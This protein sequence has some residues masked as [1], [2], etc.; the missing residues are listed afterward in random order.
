VILTGNYTPVSL[1]DIISNLFGH[2]ILF[3]IS[4]F[5]ATTGN[6]LSLV[7]SYCFSTNYYGKIWVFYKFTKCLYCNLEYSHAKFILP[8]L[9]KTFHSLTS[10]ILR[11]YLNDISG[12]QFEKIKKTYQTKL[13]T[14]AK[15]LTTFMSVASK[16]KGLKLLYI[17]EKC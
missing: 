6:K 15:Y 8:T 12:F 3:C 10:K 5:V 7:S 14:S 11:Q 2:Y 13:L 4:T 9:M 16:K 17:F 1:T